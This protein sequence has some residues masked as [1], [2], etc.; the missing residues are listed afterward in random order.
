MRIGSAAVSHMAGYRSSTVITVGR[1]R[2]IA[3]VGTIV[4]VIVV[5]SVRPT[6][7]VLIG[8]LAVAALRVRRESALAFWE[9]FGESAAV[10]VSMRMVG[11]MLPVGSQVFFG[12][13]VQFGFFLGRDHL[14][15]AA[16]KR[17]LV[18]E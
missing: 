3:I 6:A 11:I 12:N 7:P 13:A 15:W 8:I 16:R 5:R 17:Q 2:L 1:T 10:V 4:A 18:R 9:A 14:C